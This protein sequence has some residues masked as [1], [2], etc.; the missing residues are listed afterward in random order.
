VDI[1]PDNLSKL[2]SAHKN[3]RISDYINELRIRDAALLLAE[4]DERIIDIAFSVGFESV[5]T[6]NRAFPK[7]M[8]ATPEQYRKDHQNQQ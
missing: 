4:S 7:Y 1:H 2:F 5:R 3:M 8:H 6:F